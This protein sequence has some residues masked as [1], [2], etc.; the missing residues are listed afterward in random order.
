MVAVE[1]VAGGLAGPLGLAVGTEGTLYVAEALAGQLTALDKDGSRTVLYQNTEG[2]F[3]TGVD[4]TGRGNVAF[5]ISLPPEFDG[6]LPDDTALMTVQPNGKVRQV[7]SLLEHEVRN[8]PDAQVEY[9]P[10]GVDEECLAE[11]PEEFRP[12]TGVVESNPYA[13]KI[14]PGG[15]L[16]A[17]AAA[18]TIVH[19]GRNGRMSTVAVL[20]PVPQTVTQDLV[21]E[22]AADPEYPLILPDC[23][24]GSTFLGEPVPTDIEVGPDGNYY[25]TGLPGFP[26]AEGAGKVWRVD[27]H[28]G[29]VTEVASGFFGAVDL[30]VAPDGTI[31]VAEFFAGRISSVSGGAVATLVEL[32][33]AS[34]VEIDRDGSIL[35]TQGVFGPPGSLVRITR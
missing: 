32:P 12:R 1:P 28:S 31:Y 16:V 29:Q 35:A 26:E 18:N 3:V 27:P 23:I 19:V 22:L 5:T 9:G 34:T 30:A 21:D 7:A 15:Y 11:L 4:A 2:A 24:I 17:D 14:I 6:G 8:N 33:Q 25:V 20:P 13:V 10:V